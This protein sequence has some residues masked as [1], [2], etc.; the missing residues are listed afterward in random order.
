MLAESAHVHVLLCKHV[1]FCHDDC[2]L[3]GDFLVIPMSFI[4][5]SM[6]LG[7]HVT[8]LLDLYLFQKVLQQ[9]KTCILWFSMSLKKCFKGVRMT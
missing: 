4:P 8:T 9:T 2:V 5:R 1:V 7:L 6:A 3:F